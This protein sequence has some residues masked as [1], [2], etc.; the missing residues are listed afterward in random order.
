[1]L[2]ELEGGSF[3]TNFP[4][5]LGSVTGYSGKR[6]QTEI[7]YSFVSFLAPGLIYHCD[8]SQPD[9]KPVVRKT[10]SSNDI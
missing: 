6:Y 10:L 5:E 8:L 1:M 7:F 3:I 4:L 2:H 9:L